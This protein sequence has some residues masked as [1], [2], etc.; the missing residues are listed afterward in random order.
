[1]P[2]VEN[3]SISNKN[4]NENEKEEENEVEEIPQ[5]EEEEENNAEET[6]LRRSTRTSQ[7]STRLRNFVTYKVRYPIQNFVIY[8]YITSSHGALLISIGKEQEPNTYQEAIGNHV[9]RKTMK[10][11]TKCLRKK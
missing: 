9:W 2:E 5:I 1:M 10:K 8:D 6:Q 3:S 7:P 11:K 4:L